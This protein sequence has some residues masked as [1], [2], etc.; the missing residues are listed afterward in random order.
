MTTPTP[1]L[2]ALPGQPVQWPY[3]VR[4]LQA[5]MLVETNGA[6]TI[7][8]AA[9]PAVFTAA[10][11][12]LFPYLTTDAPAT[13]TRTQRA[14]LADPVLVEGEW[15]QEWTVR[16][17]T[18]E[19]LAQWDA[20]NLPQPQWIEFG[21][22]LSGI[23]AVDDLLGAVEAANRPLERMLSGGML[24]AAQGDARTFLAAWGHCLSVGLITAEL[25]ATV[26]ALASDY[27]LPAAFIEALNPS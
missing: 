10:P 2:R 14:E 22:A 4:Q 6:T 8:I 12:Y 23:P 25:V 21:L 1:Y 7:S 9:D 24:Q 27:D 15:Q 26:S 11:Y 16:D 3:S 20:L 19:E 5:D 18:E 17:A 13:D